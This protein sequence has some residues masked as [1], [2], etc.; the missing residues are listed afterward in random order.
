MKLSNEPTQPY[1]GQLTLSVP[2]LPLSS[3]SP[4][5]LL[6]LQV[7]WYESLVASVQTLQQQSSK[8]IENGEIGIEQCNGGWYT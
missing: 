7:L 4:L 8:S 5:S 2:A 1:L 3:L 6:P